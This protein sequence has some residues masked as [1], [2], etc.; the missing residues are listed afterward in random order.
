MMS[1]IARSFIHPLS[2][3]L[4]ATKWCIA[5]PGP[6]QTQ[7]PLRSRFC[8]ASPRG[9]ATRPGEDSNPLQVEHR[10]LAGAVS[11]QRTLFADGVGALEYPVL[12]GGEPGEDFGL[13]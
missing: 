1:I 13:Y 6:F 10:S 2:R 3:T 9:A 8:G 11:A 7:H 12:P 4:C 5:D